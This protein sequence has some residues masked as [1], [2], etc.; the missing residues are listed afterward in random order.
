MSNCSTLGNRLE[1][2][3]STRDDERPVVQKKS[4][5]TEIEVA[6]SKIGTDFL[7]VEEPRSM[8]GITCSR[9]SFRAIITPRT[10]NDED[11]AMEVDLPNSFPTKVYIN[12]P[13]DLK[14]ILDKFELEQK[15]K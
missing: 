2:I 9:E 1:R 6:W 14:T 5:D 7:L 10:L 15:K 12:T 4:T 13:D 3:P 11:C 8:P